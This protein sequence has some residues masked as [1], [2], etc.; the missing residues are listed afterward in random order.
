MPALRG[1]LGAYA[2]RTQA[3]GTAAKTAGGDRLTPRPTG[4]DDP[5]RGRRT[6]GFVVLSI[7]A[8]GVATGAV[9]GG[10]VLAN[11]SAVTDNCEGDVCNADGMGAVRRVRALGTVST[12]GFLAGAAGVV[13]GLFLVITAPRAPYFDS[14]PPRPKGWSPVVSSADVHGALVGLKRA[15]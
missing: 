11:K 4:V 6:V 5:G 7:G 13:G 2:P 10:I 3:E 8:V 14:A 12:I 9:A 1:A 15:W